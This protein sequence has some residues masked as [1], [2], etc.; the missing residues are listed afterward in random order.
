MAAH[1]WRV[2]RARYADKGIGDIMSQVNTM[3]AV[4]D[5]MEQVGLESAVSSC[6]SATEAKTEM[7][8]YFD[9]LYKPD[10]RAVQLNGDGYL[11]PPPGFSE[12][13]MEASFDAFLAS[14]VN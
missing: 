1:N 12:E 10:V 14:G 3:H 2:L 13:E 9:K 4:L 8:R 6:K 7:T 5:V 11:P